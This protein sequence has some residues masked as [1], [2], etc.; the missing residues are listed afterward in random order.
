MNSRYVSNGSDVRMQGLCGQ[1][2][3]KHMGKATCKAFPGGIPD[4]FLSGE[5]EH[6]KP[7]KNDDGIRF[8]SLNPIAK[9]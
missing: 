7:Y 5:A 9:G 8:E 2:R 3:H 6:T 4:L 1:C